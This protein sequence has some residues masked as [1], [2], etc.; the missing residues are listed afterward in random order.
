[1]DCS[2]TCGACHGG[3]ACDRF[4]G[5]CQGCEENY[6]SPLCAE[7]TM[8]AS[9]DG[10]VAII[11]GSAAGVVVFIALVV[12]IVIFIVRRRRGAPT[13][14]DAAR[15]T[16]SV[17]H[18]NTNSGRVYPNMSVLSSD[19]PAARVSYV[20]SAMTSQYDYIDMRE[21]ASNYDKLEVYENKKDIT[22]IYTDLKPTEKN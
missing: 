17:N 21:A 22:N 13:Q 8:H 2:L 7:S 18:D 14:P 15:T 4:N 20:N 11:P 16:T 12:A 1:M 5:S 9:E 10:N 3:A 19:R 6:N